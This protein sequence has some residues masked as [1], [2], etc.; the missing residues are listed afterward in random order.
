VA[1]VKVGVI[2]PNLNSCGLTPLTPGARAIILHDI[3]NKYPLV[4]TILIPIMA[5][6]YNSN[7]YNIICM[8]V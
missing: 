4:L 5:E 8:I 2:Y 6:M 1:V 3:D 7:I